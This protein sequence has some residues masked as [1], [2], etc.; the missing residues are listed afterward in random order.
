MTAPHTVLLL[1][2]TG[3]TGGRVLQELLTRGVEV[4]AV[5]RSAGRLP[6]G[7]A[8]DPRLRVVE[9]DVLGLS[10]ERLADL[11]RGCDAVV[12]CLGHRASL[13]GV[14]GAPRDLVTRAA[15]RIFRA[16]TTLCPE[17][18]VRFVLMS[19]VSVD[20]PGARDPRRGRLER[21]FLRVL[22]GLVPP[23]R[24]NQ[25]AADFLAGEVGTDDPYLRWVAV[26]PDSLREG[27][28]APYALHDGLVD[29][30][31]RPGSTTMAGVADFMARLVTDPGT[32]AEWRGRMPVVVTETAR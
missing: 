14:F 16:L 30:L 19:S 6:A 7:V 2:G 25:R 8:G 23:A 27:E 18:P 11:V 9:G 24:D 22:R 5:V 20:R 10:D 17:R 32:W 4:R 31:L 15:R 21:A 29:S 3:R 13:A 1:G 26:R 12:S 28:A